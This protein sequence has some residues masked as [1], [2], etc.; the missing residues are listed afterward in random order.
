MAGIGFQLKRI[1]DQDKSIMGLIKGY[2]MSIITLNG[3]MITLIVMVSL[4]RMLVGDI[5]FGE[6][7]TPLVFNTIMYCFILV[8]V[9]Q[10]VFVLPFVRYIADQ[11]YYKQYA[12]MMSSFYGGSAV[13]MGLSV[14][15]CLVFYGFA[16]MSLDWLIMLS[17]FFSLISLIWIQSMM[18][19]AINDY[20]S[21]I[22][23]YVVGNTVILIACLMTYVVPQEYAAMTVMLSFLLGFSVTAGWLLHTIVNTFGRADGNYFAWT[24]YLK[25]HPSLIIVG[26]GYAFGLFFTDI[27]Y[28]IY[29]Y[30]SA[31]IQGFLN[32]HKEYDIAFFIGS[33]VFIVG[34]VFFAVRFETRLYADLQSVLDA[35]NGSENLHII[36]HQIQT[37]RR[38]ISRMFYHLFMVQGT[39]ALTMALVPIAL[40]PDL[41]L[42][43]HSI[44]IYWAYLIGFSATVVVYAMKIVLLY[45]DQTRMAAVLILQYFTG[46]IC[47]TWLLDFT[48]GIPGLGLAVG[49][50]L[51]IFVGWWIIQR[52]LST[53][54]SHL[55]QIHPIK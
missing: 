27:V 38:N 28:R 7:T 2:S 48:T 40:F 6:M 14:L 22:T 18:V 15:F 11:I 32:V 37:F 23:A 47:S 35:V 21:I 1:V 3:P 8:L 34:M 12:R 20:R 43:N 52:Q 42:N 5:G 16:G 17:S 46:I 13:A 4:V 54:V 53:M 9:L 25:K 33:L 31:F 49:A 36:L 41:F 30:D 51:A 29:S 24:S 55:Y 10:S 39:I 19:S 44:M 50:N 26:M 45:I